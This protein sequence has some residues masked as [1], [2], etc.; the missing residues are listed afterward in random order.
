MRECFCR[1]R[2]TGECFAENIHVVFFWKLP[3]KRACDV[4]LEWI[5]E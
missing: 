5:L 2:H 3:G 1:S 4:F